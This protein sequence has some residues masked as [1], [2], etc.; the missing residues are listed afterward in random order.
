MVLVE[1][2]AGTKQIDRALDLLQ[3]HGPKSGA[4]RIINIVR[5]ISRNPA[6]SDDQLRRLQEQVTQFQQLV[7]DKMLNDPTMSILL[8]LA[9]LMSWRGDL[10]KAQ[11]VYLSVIEK[12]PGNIYALNNLAVLLA[13]NGI[14][15]RGAMTHVEKAIANDGPMDSL[16]DT[17]GL[18]QLAAGQSGAAVADFKLSIFEKESAENQF[19]LALALSR[20]GS[21]KAA[22]DALAAAET[23]G[24]VEEDLH[25]K[26]RSMLNILR[27]QIG[28]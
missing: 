17:R 3:E 12:S 5:K 1:F 20:I 16:L 18:V 27:K 2:L 24:L 25:P 11:A 4:S 28:N 13:L 26:E 19:H 23:L 14:N 8:T 22:K 6:A 7:D 15:P 9:D 10:T 21:L